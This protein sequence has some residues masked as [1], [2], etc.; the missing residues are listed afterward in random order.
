MRTV[1]QLALR[2]VP[3]GQRVLMAAAQAEPPVQNATPEVRVI[4]YHS[5]QKR[6]QMDSYGKGKH[7]HEPTQVYVC[8]TFMLIPFLV[9]QAPE[10]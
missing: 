7:H 4:F 6:L 8:L 3:K 9:I 1:G 2:K 10:R 5:R